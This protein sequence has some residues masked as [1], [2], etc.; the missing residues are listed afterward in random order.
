MI[1]I[2][3]IILDN[4]MNIWGYC[5]PGCPVENQGYFY[6]FY[7]TLKILNLYEDIYRIFEYDF[8]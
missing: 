5:E 1:I 3:L 8:Q 7:L 6:T 4:F 2:N